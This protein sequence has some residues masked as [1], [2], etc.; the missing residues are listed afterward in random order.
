MDC[1]K[2]SK[3]DKS[4]FVLGMQFT[5]MMVGP[6]V[7]FVLGAMYLQKRYGLGD[8]IMVLALLLSILSMIAGMYNFVKTAIKLTDDTKKGKS[9]ESEK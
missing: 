2:N 1:K 6:V 8:N 5:S 3:N 9:D 7:F 4:L